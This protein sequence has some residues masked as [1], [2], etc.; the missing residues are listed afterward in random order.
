MSLGDIRLEQDQ[1]CAQLQV[2]KVRKYISSCRLSYASPGSASRKY[3]HVV[4]LSKTLSGSLAIFNYFAHLPSGNHTLFFVFFCLCLVN[5]RHS[6]WIFWDTRI[7]L[8]N[9]LNLGIKSWPP[10]A[11]RKSSQWRYHLVRV[12]GSDP[13]TNSIPWA[14]SSRRA[15]CMFLQLLFKQQNHDI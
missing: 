8:M 10:P 15:L 5:H 6:P 7:L 3:I 13:Q 2:Q 12:L 11:K 4:F 14:L 1:T 9:L